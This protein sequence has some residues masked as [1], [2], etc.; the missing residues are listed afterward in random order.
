[1]LKLKRQLQESAWKGRI[2]YGTREVQLQ[3]PSQVEKEILKGRRPWVSAGVALGVLPCCPVPF[4]ASWPWGLFL[5]GFSML[6]SSCIPRCP[7][8]GQGRPQDTHT[9]TLP[10]TT[11]LSHCPADD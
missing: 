5:P 1:M 11:V 3:D 7:S 4:S 2:S 10:V 6:P 9:P 8:S